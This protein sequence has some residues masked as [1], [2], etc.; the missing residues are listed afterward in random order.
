M[1][2]EIA[3]VLL[4]FVAGAAHT[5]ASI[6]SVC[7]EHPEKVT[8]LFDALDLDRAGLESVKANVAAQDWPGACQVLL[9]YYRSSARA[10]KM[11]IEPAAKTEERDAAADAILNDTYTLYQISAKVPRR[12]DGG[13]DWTCNGPDG[14]KEWGWGLNRQ[15]WV[16]TL[17]GAYANTGN[18]I[19]VAAFDALIRDWVISN[20]YPG[21]R[22]STPQWRGL[23]VHFRTG[24]AWPE[25]FYRL[26]EAPEFTPAARL[27][28]L[29]SI[30]DH[31]HYNR[32]F[33]AQKGNWVTMEMNGLASAAVYWPEF[34]E[35]KAWF[36][37]AMARMTPE[38]AGQVYPDGAQKEL[39]SSYH[40]VALRNFERFLQLAAEANLE[41]P[42]DFK[43]CIER[44]YHY[45]AYTM[46][47]SGEGPLNNDSDLHSMR[48]E[49]MEKAIE[50]HRPDWTYLATNGAEGTP[51][52]GPS[53]T[54][55]PWAGQVILRSGWDAEA[56]WAFLDAGPM[57]IGHWH[58][59][60]LHLSVAAHG[61]D[62]LV[63]GGRFTYQGGPWRAYFVGSPSH[64]VLLVD[65]HGQNA[66]D[67]EALEPMHGNWAFTPEYDFTR[68][69]FDN[70]YEGV[71]DTVT[72]ARAVLYV[73]G[74]YWLVVDRVT[75]K[76]PHDLTALWHF[77]PECAVSAEGPDAVS[78][79]EG[80]GNVRIVPSPGVSWNLELVRGR[81]EPSIQGWW[82]RQYNSKEPNACAVY[83][84]R[85]EGSVISYR[86]RAAFLKGR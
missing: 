20:P 66:C 10:E 79:D 69:V 6:E 11:R 54:V 4:S 43:A 49:L 46:N 48:A 64:N 26:Q 44:M 86:P 61:R 68:G 39:T 77:H 60:K 72:H 36:D 19:Y 74:G 76:E 67:K 27:L 41:A 65:G 53:S 7:R 3:M 35:A 30:P 18:P 62:I 2:P 45:L 85:M 14:D 31:A 29:S 55:F 84:A 40:R 8:R 57:G 34:K 16:G 56:H 5:G 80:K 33:H 22:S 83:T 63:D 70:G 17:V 9:D 81:E 38:L 13:L 71:E 28:M 73:R 47:P 58:Y 32:N 42:P 21:E 25:A 37:Y 12:P 75:S 78:T 15:Q 24:I 59:D 51:P 1:L 50:F 52:E 82:S 23:E